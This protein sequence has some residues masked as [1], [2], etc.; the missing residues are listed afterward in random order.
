M[1]FISIKIRAT[2]KMLYFVQSFA[3]LL[4]LT[5]HS[6]AYAFKDDHLGFDPKFNK[7]QAPEQEILF[8]T[9][10]PSPVYKSNATYQSVGME[11]VYWLTNTFLDLI[12]RDNVLP[13]AINSSDIIDAVNRGPEATLSLV[14]E[15]WQDLLLQYIGLLTAVIVGILLAV[16]LPFVGFIVCCCRCAGK[17]GAYPETYYDKKSDSC[18]RFCTGFLLCVFVIAVVFGSACA[19]LTNQYKYN[20]MTELPGKFSDSLQDANRF[21]EHTQISSKLLLVDNFIKLEKLVIERLENGGATI[22]EG[23][24]E[25]TGAK[26]IE[27][28]HDLVSNLGKVKRNLKDIVDDTNELDVKIAQLKEG[29][30]K[31]QETLGEVLEDC[32]D[33]QVCRNFLNDYN[34][35]NDLM[36]TQE[37][38]NVQ[39]RLPGISSALSDINDLIENRIEEKV[40]AGKSKFD[41]VDNNI[42]S[43][44]ADVEP[45]V[46]DELGKFGGDLKSYNSKFQSAMRDLNFPTAEPLPE[47]TDDIVK[48]IYYLGLGMSGGVLLILL[49]YILG[50]FYGMCGNT[51]SETYT[52]DCCDRSTGANMIATATYLTFLLSCPLLLLTTV[53]FI[54]GAGL[55]T[56]VCETLQSPASS[57][58]FREVDVRFIQPHLQSLF[59]SYGHHKVS[60]LKLL[61]SCHNNET[62]YTIAGLSSVYDVKK[63]KN[64]RQQYNMD[65]IERDLN[66]RQIRG[67]QLV[68]ADT[69]KD[70]EFL[71]RSQLTRLDL[72]KFKKVS[73][74]EIIEID[75]RSFVRQL[76]SLREDITRD[77]GLRGMTTKLSN[78]VL[79]LENM[80]RVA[81]QVK[82]T[83]RHLKQSIKL[84]EENMKVNV[85]TL[86]DNIGTLVREANDATNVLNNEGADILRQLTVSHVQET[87]SLVDTFVGSIIDGFHRDVGYCAPLSNSYNTSVAALCDQMVQPFNGFW[88]SIGWC[89]I[90][91]LPC[92]IISL[93]LTSLYRKT[94]KY[95][96]P[97][98]DVE[99]QP[100]DNKRRDQRRGHRRSYSRAENFTRSERT[101]SRALPPLPGEE[102]PHSR[103][104][105]SRADQQQPPRYSSNPSLNM[106]QASAP[107]ASRDYERD[108]P[109]PYYS[110]Q[111]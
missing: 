34:I 45:L 36:L 52:G 63:L 95:P 89:C 19:F 20:G 42:D 31:S 93:S 44:L 48:Y 68:S 109:P 91:Y 27:S 29:L 2:V 99:T 79:Y 106:S 38:Q 25:K 67:I 66:I 33:A 55:D 84:M 56:I 105:N 26:A 72:A 41:S 43:A 22:K 103:Y 5:K 98:L 15:H 71:S 32:Q 1:H 18:K 102:R 53:H 61:E 69:S 104:R 65:K 57:D 100:L 11:Q 23:L 58:V 3:I 86:S 60:T 21:V 39:F 10:S 17:C 30:A 73:E 80:M 78:E 35:K 85:G 13:A 37:Y 111:H 70:L 97:T 51:P 62:L 94:E 90:L 75:L 108:I 50:L 88:A 49:F 28:L 83:I 46:K 81:E 64:W 87:L 24:S 96:G 4:A 101:S 12:L 9:V 110:P 8:Q 6:T 76:R 14:K 82:L 59:S 7:H 40:S 77:P 54:I 107:P 47:I 74:E 92:V 16:C